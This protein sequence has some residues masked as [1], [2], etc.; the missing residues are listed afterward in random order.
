MPSVF[1]K[2][3]YYTKFAAEGFL[4]MVGLGRVV[5]EMPKYTVLRIVR[6]DL[7]IREYGPMK[8]IEA[9]MQSGDRKEE[10]DAFR[11]LAGYIT[12]A[13]ESGDL[14]AMT[15]P[16]ESKKETMRFFL[17]EDSPTPAAKDQQVTVGET[18][19]AKVA[20]L[21]FPGRGTEENKKKA[22]ERLLSIVDEEGI[23]TKGDPY[24]FFYDAPFTIPYFRRNEVLIALTE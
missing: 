9:S 24:F 14:I 1:E 10:S 19:P 5:Y 6:G 2:A 20:A 18:K 8:Y 17:P 7:E 21:V 3:L 23:K 13:N 22:M 11:R 15:A 4:G 12:G 16:V